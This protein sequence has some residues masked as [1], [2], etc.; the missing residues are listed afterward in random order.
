MKGSVIWPLYSSLL[1]FHFLSCVVELW[2]R[3][4]EREYGMENTIRQILPSFYVSRSG[5]LLLSS[6]AWFSFMVNEQLNAQFFPMYLFQFP[7]CFE[8]P[9]AHHQEN[10]FYQYNLW[11][12]SLCVG[13]HFVWRSEKNFFSDLNTKL[14]PKQSDIYQRLYRY[15]WF[16]WWWARGCSKHEENW[17]KYTEKNCESRWSYAMNHNRMHGQQN[18]KFWFSVYLT[19]LFSSLRYTCSKRSSGD[20]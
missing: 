16:S 1:S 8:Q 18:I 2:K 17:N 4:L 12:M 5:P 6:H 3:R 11:Y 15:N 13:E 19:K 10:Q 14:S 9:R 20:L 7:A